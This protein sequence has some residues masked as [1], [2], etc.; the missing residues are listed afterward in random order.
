ML[1]ETLLR[2]L[3]HEGVV[4]I[5]SQAGN[6]TP[7]LVN[8]WNSYV[9]VSGDERLLIPAGGMQRTEKNISENRAVLLTLG[10]REVQ[11][12]RGSGAGFLISGTAEFL[13]S[14]PEFE[15]IRS[16]F[17]WARA[18]LVVRIKDIAQTL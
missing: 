4:T 14:G 6:G 18:A 17:P 5:A 16:K 2:V 11:G 1:P 9:Q 8:T 7:H 10:S 15:N 3:Q 12:K 13:Y